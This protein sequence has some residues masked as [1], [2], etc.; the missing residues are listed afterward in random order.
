M[1]A[2]IGLKAEWEVDTSLSTIKRS[3]VRILPKGSSLPVALKIL[4]YLSVPCSANS[5]EVYWRLLMQSDQLKLDLTRFSETW[6]ENLCQRSA[7]A[8]RASRC[9]VSWRRRHRPKR[10]FRCQTQSSR[11]TIIWSFSFK[12]CDRNWWNFDT[13]AKLEVFILN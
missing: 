2:S 8:S 11:P 13:S 9:S 1:K 3:K 10:T 12:K 6:A 7:P 4:D 5:L